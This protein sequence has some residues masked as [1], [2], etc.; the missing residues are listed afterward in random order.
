MDKLMIEGINREKTGTGP[1]HRSRVG[2]YIPAVIYDK[3]QNKVIN[4]EQEEMSEI[5]RKQGDNALVEIKMGSNIT[6]ALIKEVQ[7]DPVSG[8]PLH[9]DFKPVDMS[10]NIQTK[11]P[12]RFTGT[13]MLKRQGGVIQSQRS[14]IQIE[15]KPDNLPKSVNIDVSKFKLG[16]SIKVSDVEFA[17]EISIVGNLNEVI[18]TL[19]DTR[20]REVLVEE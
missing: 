14:E 20:S 19:A 11:V 6:T 4:V 12:V 13:D 15:C 1:A 10:K 18:A 5:L 3:V 8:Q 17:G 7:R 2:G 9:I 16:E